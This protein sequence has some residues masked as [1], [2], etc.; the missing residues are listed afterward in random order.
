MR[1]QEARGLMIEKMSKWMKVK[2]EIEKVLK[3]I[4]EKYSI[5]GRDRIPYRNFAFA[6]FKHLRNKSWPP[7]P[8]L[9]KAL[10]AYYSI[11]YEINEGILNEVALKVMELVKDSREKG[12]LTEV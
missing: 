3:E 10:S 12:I 4:F 11:L 9:S 6:L 1:Y 2:V 7:D 8:R 5:G